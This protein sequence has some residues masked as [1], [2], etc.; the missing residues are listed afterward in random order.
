M[1]KSA[2]D[3]RQYWGLRALP[4]DNVPDPR[5]YV[6]CTQ[7]DTAL[8][9]LSHGIQTR[10]GMLLLTGDIGCGKTLLSRRLILGLPADGYDVALV[11]NPALSPSE[12]LEEVLSQFGLGLG[13]SKAARLQTLNERLQ[14][15][16]QKG[17]SSVL[18]VDEAQSIESS[19]GFEELRLLTNFQLNDRYLLTVVLIGQP[20][21]RD[22]VMDIP[23]LNQRIAVRAH[24]GPFT[25]EE[26]TA[27]ITARMEAAT[28]RTDIFTKEA[29]AIIHEQS[30]GIGRLINALCDQCLFAGAIE[31]ALQVDDRLVQRVGQFKDTSVPGVMRVEEATESI[32]SNRSA[33][34]SDEDVEVYRRSIA[35]LVPIVEELRVER[36]RAMRSTERVAQ[37]EKE[38]GRVGELESMLVEEREQVA[39]LKKKLTEVFSAADRVEKLESLGEQVA[40]RVRTLERAFAVE[41]EKSKVFGVSF[42]DA[43]RAS[44]R[45]QVFESLLQMER[46]LKTFW[47]GSYMKLNE[48]RG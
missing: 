8:R 19:N 16:E 47:R 24:L 34:M 21:L 4:F 11:A 42:P 9:W 46:E 26:T 23:Q 41:Q 36:D 17:I 18:V 5:F 37:L 39:L 32:E 43:E 40:A 30:R 10:K 48:S 14:V 22:R 15:N 35:G 3:Y 1:M 20:E 25:A 12:L 7:H 27:Y 44:Q 38:L 2:G 13:Q 28:D 33:R 45:V 6:P 31:E 29:I